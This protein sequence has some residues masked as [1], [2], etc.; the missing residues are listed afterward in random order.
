MSLSI[1]ILEF[2]SFAV[3]QKLELNKP[4][5]QEDVAECFYR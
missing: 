4:K 2:L 5:W 3:F 1:V